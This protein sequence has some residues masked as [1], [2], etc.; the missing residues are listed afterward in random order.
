MLMK[1][2]SIGN[3]ESVVKV[4]NHNPNRSHYLPQKHKNK[5]TKKKPKKLKKFPP[6]LKKVRYTHMFQYTDV[7]G[8]TYLYQLYKQVL[9]PVDIDIFCPV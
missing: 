9:K 8:K 6:P 3:V 5:T 1:K 2:I 7:V 4:I